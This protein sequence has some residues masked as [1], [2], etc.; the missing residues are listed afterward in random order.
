MSRERQLIERTY[1]TLGMMPVESSL[2]EQLRIIGVEPGMTLLV[3]SSLSSVGWVP[4]GAVAVIRAL[5]RALGPEGT[6]VMPTH[7]N[8]LTDPARWKNPPVPESWWGPIREETPA[9]DPLETPSWWMGAIPETFRRMRGVVRSSHPHLS[10]AAWGR[11]AEEVIRGH[12]EDPS[13]LG[14][15]LGDE[16]PVGRVYDMD[17]RVL[18]IGVGH[19]SNT[20]LHLAEYRAS[21][22]GKAFGEQ[23]APVIAG[24]K[25]QW[26][27]YEDLAFDSDD[28][29]RLGADF[30]RDGGK[31]DDVKTGELGM[32]EARFMRQ[33]ALVDFAVQWME[34]N[35]G[36]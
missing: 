5:Q 7:T 1:E 35:R 25:R 22:E 27:R 24:G 18:L 13:R 32:A 26:V 36:K 23:W 34:R 20:S 16:S 2:A 10:F 11:N 14:A 17:G 12:G 29:E 31:T 30:E 33:R 28:F 6:L 15:G 21:Y 8:H 9:F 19:G 3:H 4:G